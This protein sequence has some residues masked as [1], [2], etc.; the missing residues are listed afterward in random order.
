MDL[1]HGRL[2]KVCEEPVVLVKVELGQ[3]V[4]WEPDEQVRSEHGVKARSEP[5]EQ[6]RSVL[7]MVWLDRVYGVLAAQ[8]EALKARYLVAWG[9][10]TL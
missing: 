1:P 5:N 8:G 4:H 9:G 3:T 7:E 6:V 2:V 10:P